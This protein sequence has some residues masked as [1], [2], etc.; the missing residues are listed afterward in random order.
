[1]V[2]KNQELEEE[3][4]S[5]MGI[6]NL[7]ASVSSENPTSR[8]IREVTSNSRRSGLVRYLAKKYSVPV[9]SEGVSGSRLRFN[10]VPEA[11]LLLPISAR[12]L[13]VASL[14]T[15]RTLFTVSLNWGSV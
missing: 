8:R 9:T 13:T 12:S 4:P 3:L 7:N 2:K 14:M 15:G 1:M 10:D 5:E 6:S 11:E